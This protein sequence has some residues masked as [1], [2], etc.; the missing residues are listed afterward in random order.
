MKKAK[1]RPPA[2]PTW[3]TACPDWERRIVARESLIPFKPLFPKEAGAA[4]EVFNALQMVD[5]GATMGELS[6]PWVTD[7]VSAIFGAYDADAG[8]RLIREFFLLVS[9]K[10]GKSM[11][12]AAIMVTALIRNWRQEAEFY[13][14]APTVEIANNS[15]DPAQAMIKADEELNDLFQV[16]PHL[17]TIRHRTTGA[18][19]KVVAA[20]SETVGGKKGTGVFID[21]LWLFGK[22]PNAENMF[23]EATGG[24]MS[25]PEGFVIWS[26][27]QSDT[28]PAG[29]FSQKLQYAREVRDGRILAPRFLPLIYEFPEAMLEAGAHLEPKNFYVTNPNLGASVDEETLLDDLVQAQNTSEESVRGFLAKHLNVQIGTA[30]RADRWAGADFWERCGDPLLTLEA[31][32]GRCEVAVVGIDGGGLDDLLGVAV[33][34]RERETRRWLHWAH[35]WAH[36]IVLERRKAIASVLL[37]FEKDGDLTIVDLPGDDVIAVA[38]ICD[39]LRA[40]QLLP[41]KEAIGVD[42]AG[43]GDILDEL[44]SKKDGRGFT[45]DQI[46]AISQGWRLNAAIKQ[47]ERKVA[48]GEFVHGDSRLMSWCVGN[49]RIV[50]Q[51][52][53][54]SITKQVSGAAKIDPL[55]ATFNANTLMALNPESPQAAHQ[56]FF[57]G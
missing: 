53:A 30:L 38:D 8:R 47:T 21:E 12:A 4:L 24:K 43:I 10:N 9:K 52:N 54:V 48:G 1:A 27:T 23:R 33:V 7:F 18:K 26:S 42:A 20:D 5:A 32:I 55:M 34:G 2:A 35:A 40:A 19:L 28:P 44:M 39:R 57:I 25:R 56:L 45:L 22:N 36:Q 3:S 14:L 6:R 13:I 17:R 29:V 49:A 50:P 31:L 37:D 41:E 16:Q 46:K 15:F 51:G 11:D